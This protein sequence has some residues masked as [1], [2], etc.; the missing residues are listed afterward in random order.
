MARLLHWVTCLLAFA[1][2]ASADCV[3]GC[4]FTYGLCCADCPPHGSGSTCFADCLKE[5]NQCLARC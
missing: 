1:L 2:V 5:R 4:A 3:N